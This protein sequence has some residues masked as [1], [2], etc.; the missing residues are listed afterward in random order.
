[1]KKVLGFITLVELFIVVAI[2]GILAA[3]V[4]QPPLSQKSK[5]DT[6][7]VVIQS[8]SIMDSN[9]RSDCYHGHVI[10]PNGNQMI[11]ANGHGIPCS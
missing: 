7:G 3:V 6:N 5:H 2:I 1:M 4:I 10:Q 8:T 9:H 11:D